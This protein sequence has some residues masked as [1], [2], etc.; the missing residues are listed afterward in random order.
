[1]EALK[2]K[3][4]KTAKI[5][6]PVITF[7]LRVIRLIRRGRAVPKVI[8]P[9]QNIKAWFPLIRASAPA[10]APMEAEPNLSLIHI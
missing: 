1:M 10:R 9:I 8:P 3:A 7:W 4:P 5:A 2:N 6:P